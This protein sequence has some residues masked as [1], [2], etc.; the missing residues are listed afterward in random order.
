M[1][2]IEYERNTGV[3]LLIDA[4]R[5]LSGGD[6]FTLGLQLDTLTGATPNGAT[7]SNVAQTFTQSS[8]AGSYR[9]E[10]GELPAD[11]THMDTRLAVE[12]GYRDQHS[13]DLVINYDGHVSMEFD[14]LSFRMAIKS[15][16]T[17]TIPAYFSV[18]AVSIIAC[19]RSVVRRYR[20]HS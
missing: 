7:A 13:P 4:S 1:N 14:Y 18:M 11:D 2:Y 15:I 6:Q 9:V 10:A 5:P 20:W 17:V 3:E 16:L 19:T 8:G 12:V